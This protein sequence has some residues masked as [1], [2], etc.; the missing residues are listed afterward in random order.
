MT[1]DEKC[2][3]LGGASTWRT[4]AVERVG[5]PALRMSDGPNGV[6]GEGHG[7]GRTPGVAVPVGIA[8]GATW[9]PALVG[10]I[11]DL[12]G[13]EAVRKGA[14]VLLAPTVNLQR[15]P[16]GGRVFECFSED[17]ELTAALA[18]PY[19]RG[20]QAHDVAVTVKHFVANDT[21][22]ERMTVD[23]DV[24]EAVLRELY[25][26]PFE[27]TVV[28]GGAW[29][30]MSA[31]NRL[32]GE[33]CAEN[34]RLL[35][36]ILRGEWGFDGAV[37]S[38]WY[39][40]HHT[41]PSLVAGLTVPM[42]GPRT[43]YGP[44]LQAAVEAGDV[45]EQIVDERL[46][47][48][49]ALVERTRAAERSVDQAERTID[50]PAERALCRRAAAASVVLLRNERNAL[51]LEPST[52]QR[53]A[54][55]GPNAAATKVM[56]GG[57]SS[58]QPISRRSIL[59][60]LVDAFGSAVDHRVGARIDKMAPIV[61]DERL[62]APDGRPG[63][64]IEYRN[65]PEPDA[66]VVA[67]EHHAES[68]LTY[69]GSAPPNVDP[70]SFHLRATAT[71]TPDVDGTHEL[72]LVVTGPTR[73][74]L[75]GVE[76][77]ADP[78]GKWP[79]S[80]NFFGYGSAE[81]AVAFD[82][83]AGRPI[84]L[85]VEMSAAFGFAAVRI[86]VRQ[87]ETTDLLDAAVEAASGAEA[88][89]VVVGTNDEWETE[90]N[91]RETIALPGRQD[92]LVSRVAAVN[93]RTIVVVNAGSPVTMPWAD[94]VAAIAVGWFGGM[95]M[96]NAVVDVLVGAA[97]P[98]GRLPITFPQRLGDV[99]AHRFHAPVDGVQHYREGFAMGYRG[100]I[101]AG[102]EPLFPF[103]FGLSYGDIAWGEAMASAR[104]L[105]ADGALDLFI[106]VGLMNRGTR[107][108]TAVVQ[109]YVT[110]LDRPDPKPSRQ[111]HAFTKLA[112]APGQATTAVLQLGRTAFRRWDP[113]TS[114]WRVDPGRYRVTVSRSA[115]DDHA[116]FDLEIV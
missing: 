100:M 55:I 14:H 15:V 20:V 111:L 60:A 112:L 56:G 99:P 103:G 113:A 46:I 64:L 34:R 43:I 39:G 50:D 28:D 44:R 95:E 63:M 61:A 66:P 45:D 97:D 13:V 32:G 110:A 107:P 76:V 101:D 70:A 2:R 73:L 23:V 81:Q 41:V 67:T 109:G 12:L 38:D 7:A 16:N 91:D 105:R 71:Y 22:I 58:L 80:D 65:S 69:F 25:L 93:E 36:D 85:D 102:V 74:R 30:V 4:H 31:Y 27:A 75:D 88:A 83:I 96:A 17:P 18:V 48:L 54:V 82:G 37:V 49:L 90:G 77:L 5:I 51:P 10:Q 59:A 29:G 78:D 108:G 68:L 33:H 6:R 52:V 79:R 62:R 86:G 47:E 35:T 94:D 114:S 89:I 104:Q 98:G 11:G 72:G 53:V 115:V 92:E 84:T 26:R 57:S 9:D 19:V 106:E 21:E 116:A 1:L 8:L 3:A 24:D 42:P 40:S 87:P